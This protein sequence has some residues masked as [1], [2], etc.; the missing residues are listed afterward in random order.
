MNQHELGEVVWSMQLRELH[1][2]HMDELELHL[3]Y[4][5]LEDAI[6]DVLTNYE[7]KVDN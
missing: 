6:N 1:V 5:S 3:F 7:V 2:N 4:N